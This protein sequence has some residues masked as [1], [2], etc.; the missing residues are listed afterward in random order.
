MSASFELSDPDKITVGA[1]GPAGGRTF[2]LQARQADRL[3]TLKLE[4]QQV[5]ALAEL[6]G[7]LLSDLAA[8]G[9]VP[10]GD[11]LDLE[12]PVLAEWIVG[13]MQLTFDPGSD[14]VILLAEEASSDEPDE[15]EGAIGRLAFTREQATALIR[16]GSELVSAGRPPCPLCGYPLDPSG[17]SCPKTNGHRAPTL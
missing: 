1:V 6:L 16:R 8:P 12:E 17:H 3:V 15:D 10:E 7:E 13:G 11:A 9:P 14:R 2:Y 4:K 5:A